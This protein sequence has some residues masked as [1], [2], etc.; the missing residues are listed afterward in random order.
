[1]AKLLSSPPGFL[2]GFNKLR[3]YIKVTFCGFP[4]SLL[5]GEF[6]QVKVTF[7]NQGEVPLRKLHLASSNADLFAFDRASSDNEDINV[8]DF[9]KK[10]PTLSVKRVSKILLPED[11][12]NSREDFECAMWIQGRQRFGNSTEELL[13]YYES[14]DDNPSMR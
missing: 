5:C 3:F 4:K 14:V 12:L 9:Q 11:C 6:R 13:F 10:Q 8:P 2:Y 7:S 1:M